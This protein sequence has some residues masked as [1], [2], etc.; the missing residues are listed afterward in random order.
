MNDKLLRSQ[1]ATRIIKMIDFD[2]SNIAFVP[3]SKKEADLLNKIYGFLAKNDLNLITL[4]DPEDIYLL[5]DWLFKNARLQ[6]TFL[7]N[8]KKVWNPIN[9]SLVLASQAKERENLFILPLTL[10]K[11][12]L[13]KA[14]MEALPE[15]YL[16]RER[17]TPRILK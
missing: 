4:K 2:V 9:A 14:I 5:N 6:A 1:I 8:D 7:Q 3:K 13:R 12:S 16:T 11:D 10:P 15:K 17:L